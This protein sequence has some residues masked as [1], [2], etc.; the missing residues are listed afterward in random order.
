[1]AYTDW[2]NHIYGA[3]RGIQQWR[4]M[5]ING[6]FSEDKLEDVDSKDV[7]CRVSG[8]TYRRGSGSRP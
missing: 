6:G 8:R 4:T 1:M 7:L 2:F 3:K 5:L